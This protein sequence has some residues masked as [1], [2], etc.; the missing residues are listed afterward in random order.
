MNLNQ[1]IELKTAVD[2]ESERVAAMCPEN[3]ASHFARIHSLCRNYNIKDA[4]HVFNLDEYGLSIYGMKRGG[5]IKRAVQKSTRAN[6]KGIKW[7]GSINHVIMMAVVNGSDH[8]YTPLFVL[9]GK[10]A[11]FRR[12]ENG[13]Y[14]T[15]GDYKYSIPG[16]LILFVKMNT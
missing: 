12:R 5:R 1:D 7:H 4:S 11:R 6:A 16:H 15:P 10:L 14:E 8:A 3:V 2:I 13:H 9:P